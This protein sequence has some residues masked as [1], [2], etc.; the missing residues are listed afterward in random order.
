MRP[1]PFTILERSQG[2][3]DAMRV[4]S[5]LAAIALAGG[6][7]SCASRSEQAMSAALSTRGDLE[8]VRLPASAALPGASIPAGISQPWWRMLND[9]ALEAIVTRAEATS[10]Q[11][12]RALANSAQARAA[13]RAAWSVLAPSIELSLRARDESLGRPSQELG[14]AASW[15][16]DLFGRARANAQAAAARGEAA[17]ALA[18]DVRRSV[19]TDVV[20]SYL[21][22]KAVYADRRFT[23]E[24]ADRLQDAVTKIER[25]SAAGYA[26]RLDVLRTQGR[27]YEV[28]SRL[29][30]LD[31]RA[32]ALANALALLCGEAPGGV[33]FGSADLERPALNPPLF[34]PDP[35]QFLSDRPDVRAALGRLMAAAHDS[36]AAKRAMFADLTASGAIFV[37]DIARTP[38]RLVGLD[39]N[40]VV[41]LAQPLLFRARILAQAQGADARLTEAA[42]AYE[43]ALLTALSEVDTAF[44]QTIHLRTAAERAKAQ[45]QAAAD[46][47][48]QSR[49]LFD[50]GEIGYLDV[51]VAEQTL[52]EAQRAETG[53]RRE[54]DVAWA[55]A[56]AALGAGQRAPSH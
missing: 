12:L 28:Q 9:P 47:L 43:Q 5:I 35:A 13:T 10:P 37:S 42:R 23:Q 49:R 6:L 4:W 55:R 38:G 11:I 32:G 56:M 33:A 7:S 54:A 39:N 41:A 2:Q 19:V 15:Q 53:L 44:G 29:G 21:T 51:L 31:A 30:E 48:S 17:E 50:A 34:A 46:A 25:L 52:I 45:R 1:A 14:I 18:E 22:L 26:T 8:R 27:L 20:I 40:F 24:S 36:E 3:S 16:L